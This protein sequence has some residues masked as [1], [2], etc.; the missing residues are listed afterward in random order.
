M[1]RF[2]RFA[3]C[4]LLVALM[5]CA[6]SARAA[7]LSTLIDSNGSIQV[8]DKLF[9]G[10]S[11]S[12]TGSMPAPSL[13]NIT[14][15]TDGL[16]NYGIQI[17]GSFN[18]SVVGGSSTA[19]LDYLVTVLDPNRQI[20]GVNLSGNPAVIAGSGVS[21]VTASFAPDSAATV[22]I[23]SVVPGTQNLSASVSFAPAGFQSLHV[24]DNITGTSVT[25]IET[26]SF[27]R[28]TFT[29]VPEPATA[30]LMTLALGAIYFVGR[31]RRG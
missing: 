27:V 31:K 1:I 28:Q 9:S 29:Q 24:H 11:Y 2:H 19:L 6:T 25:G 22:A 20:V 12:N 3:S 30:T 7:L 14:P 17:Q 15:Y 10:F 8:G 5:F 13:V 18:N 16:G 4:A 21:S 23:S 26:L